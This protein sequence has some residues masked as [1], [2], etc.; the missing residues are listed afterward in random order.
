MFSYF[1]AQQAIL[2]YNI[3]HY[4]HCLLVS[5][6]ISQY[7]VRSQK[8]QAVQYICTMDVFQVDIQTPKIGSTQLYGY[9]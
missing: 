3:E 5:F 8:E 2:I 1:I 4:F 9:Y 7:P 6:L